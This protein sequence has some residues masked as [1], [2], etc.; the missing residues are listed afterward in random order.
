MLGESCRRVSS[1]RVRLRSI[2]QPSRRSSSSSLSREYGNRSPLSRSPSPH[3]DSQCS[4]AYK[5]HLVSWSLL[6]WD[7]YAG[8]GSPCE[9]SIW[10]YSYPE[11]IDDLLQNGNSDHLVAELALPT[12]DF[13]LEWAKIAALAHH[14]LPVPVLVHIVKLQHMRTIALPDEGV[15]VIGEALAELFLL[16]ASHLLDLL[17]VV[18]LEYS[19]LA[20][21]LLDA[22]VDDWVLPDRE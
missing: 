22:I 2:L 12:L 14:Y 3:R 5:S 20:W 16:E 10:Q 1:E 11:A 13:A 17:E 18:V 9:S 21:G 15:L 6:P 7:S 8:T 19:L 4:I